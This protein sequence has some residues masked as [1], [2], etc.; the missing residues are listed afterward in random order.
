MEKSKEVN[1]KKRKRRRR[2][3]IILGAIVLGAV[4]ANAIGG[5]RTALNME[6]I[7]V[8]VDKIDYLTTDVALVQ[9]DKEHVDHLTEADV[10]DM[11]FEAIELAGGMDDLVTD[12]DVVVLKTNFMSAT[13]L[14]GSMFSMAMDAMGDERESDRLMSPEANGIAT[15]WRVT[16]A[17]AEY[18]RTLNPTGKIYVMEASG[19][20]NTAVKM[21]LLNY[22]NEYIPYVDEFI[23]MDDSG[24]DYTE[25]NG[26]D[27]FVAVDLGE[28]KLYEDNSDLAHTNGIYYY[29]RTY[30]EADVLISIP[31]LKN[32]QM[33]NITGA[34][35][36]VAIGATPPS[37]YGQDNGSRMLIDHSW[38]QL[39]SFIHDYYLGRPV[40]FVV[41][42]GLQ[43]IEHGPLAMGADSLE[44]VQ[45]NLRV[46]LAG[47]DAVA[48]DTIHGII[49]GVDTSKVLFLN[50]LA[51]HGLGITDVSMI[52]IVGNRSV[53]DV[54]DLYGYP[55]WP[56]SWMQ[57]VP[58]T[59][60]YEDFEA[61]TVTTD[62]TEIN[63]GVLNVNL[64][65]D[66]AVIKVEV[67]VNGEVV[68]VY[69]EMGTDI[70]FASNETVSS[71]DVVVLRCYDQFLNMTVK[72]VD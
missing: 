54:K 20:G 7:D 72:E 36:N 19:A 15:D 49:T 18:V 57:P 70:Q 53:F 5:R 25:E 67:V 8:V 31:V 6:P 23:S 69:R 59:N 41:T 3:L 35:K 65:F 30:Y 66:E 42:D 34:I 29:D 4:G 68:E 1:T 21:E 33:A 13:E 44:S 61:P 39:N 60:T 27:E 63:D 64:A 22:T 17:V 48:V 56:F 26:S 10:R 9:S 58:R 47:R 38:E 71:D 50:D 51:D 24:Q 52:N 62:N 14:S 2:L 40:D 55:G 45:K 43:S 46:I 32:H 11:V 28:Y 12:G 16:K 37:V